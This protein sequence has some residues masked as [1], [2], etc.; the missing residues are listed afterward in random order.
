[1]PDD[2]LISLC[3]GTCVCN[4][5]R[6]SSDGTAAAPGKSGDCSYYIAHPVSSQDAYTRFGFGKPDF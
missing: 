4:A 6:A 1:M 5:R 3:P 2:H